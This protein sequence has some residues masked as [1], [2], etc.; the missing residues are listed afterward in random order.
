MEFA[1]LYS[2]F[3]LVIKY[4]VAPIIESCVGR[5]YVLF[6]SNLH[7]WHDWIDSGHFYPVH[8]TAKD[9]IAVVDLARKTGRTELLPSAFY[10]CC[11]L[12]NEVLVNGVTYGTKSCKLSSGDLVICP[13]GRDAGLL[14][15][16]MCLGFAWDHPNEARR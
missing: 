12:P 1:D 7:K 10:V 6:P 5:L 16:V 3:L 13:Q 11:S 9:A 14:T 15:S 4:E 8:I 2:N